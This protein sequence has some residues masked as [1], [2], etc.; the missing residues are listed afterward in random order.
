MAEMSGP[1]LGVIETG[2]THH[3]VGHTLELGAEMSGLFFFMHETCNSSN[4]CQIRVFK[5]F[6]FYL[7][8]IYCFI[9]T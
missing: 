8:A 2:R 1:E 7:F 3:G 5:H 9:L 4:R 6:C